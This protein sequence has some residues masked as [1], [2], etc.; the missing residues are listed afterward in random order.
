MQMYSIAFYFAWASFGA[1][2]FS[3]VTN[4]VLRK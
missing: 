4:G 3:F 2:I 1:L